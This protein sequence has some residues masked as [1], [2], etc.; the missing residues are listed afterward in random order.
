VHEAARIVLPGRRTPLTTPM[1]MKKTKSNTSTKKKS[2][3]ASKQPQAKRWCF[4][5]NN[6]QDDEGIDVDLVEY[7]V[8]GEE[9]G[10]NN[11]RHFQ[12]YV[13]FKEQKRLTALKKLLGRAH[14]EIAKGSG[15]QNF[16][17]CSKDGTFQE[18]GTRPL[19]PRSVKRKR[20]ADEQQEIYSD[21]LAAP[22][23]RDGLNVVKERQSRDYCLHGEAI[24]RNLKKAKVAPHVC[25]FSIDKF[26]HAPM[27]LDKP[28]LLWGGSGLGKT[29][30]AI[31]HFKNPLVVSHIDKLKTLGP[32][33]DGVIFDDMAFK[34]WPREA[35]I[36]LLD[37]EVDRDINVRYG[38]VNIP[39]NTKKI[40]TH[41]TNN[42]F[43]HVDE[44]QEEQ[45]E[46][47]ERR[48]TRVHV[49]TKL[50]Q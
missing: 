19:E 33:H 18:H 15:W 24:E 50:Y 22:T 12:G 6:P 10:E 28:V 23:V 35:I 20:A 39:K 42:P 36:H 13:V 40:F 46:A 38:T 7:M 32:D 5:L 17:Y 11:T 2:S 44:I 45:K 26:N 48:F 30:F 47:I 29:Q 1:D 16:Q 31:A 34:H 25:Q 27:D 3:L 37:K 8:V 41:N 14:W 9:V 4:T 49:M 21:A 43:Y